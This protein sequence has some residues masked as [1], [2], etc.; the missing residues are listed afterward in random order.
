MYDKYTVGYNE[1]L[2]DIAKRFNTTK[3]E[4]LSVNNSPN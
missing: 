4:L 3:E 2:S 1:T